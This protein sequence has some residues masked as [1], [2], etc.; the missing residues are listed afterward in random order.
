MSEA[1]IIA[2]VKNGESQA[3]MDAQVDD[4]VRRGVAL[5]Y[6]NSQ[7]T[8]NEYLARVKALSQ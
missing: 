4:H 7:K 1:K 2:R 8:L 5:L 3:E 6:F